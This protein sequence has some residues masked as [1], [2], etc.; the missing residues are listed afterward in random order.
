MNTIFCKQK[1]IAI[2]TGFAEINHK[3]TTADH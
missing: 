1:T 2:G 3:K